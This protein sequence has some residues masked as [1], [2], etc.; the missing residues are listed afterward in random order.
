MTVSNQG[1]SNS[2][3]VIWDSLLGG[4]Q[5]FLLALH[6]FEKNT[7]LQKELVG[8]NSTSFDFQDLIPGTQYDTEVTA[9]LACARNS[10][11]RITGQT[12]KW[13][14]VGELLCKDLYRAF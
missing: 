3:T 8:P 5:G 7:L 13:E 6:D 2:L 1:R 4:V 9:L 12:G 14:R 10:S 11:R